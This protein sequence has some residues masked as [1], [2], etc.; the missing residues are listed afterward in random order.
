MEH[1]MDP[2]LLRFLERYVIVPVVFVLLILILL[3]GMLIRER[4]KTKWE[5]WKLK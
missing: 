3:A 2:L 1:V 4:I 5:K